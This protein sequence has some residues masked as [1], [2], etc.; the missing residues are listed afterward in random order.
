VVVTLIAVVGSDIIGESWWGCT[1]LALAEYNGHE[2]GGILHALEEVNPEKAEKWSI[3][4]L[5]YVT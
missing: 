3:T 4:P 1:P 2:V 5:S